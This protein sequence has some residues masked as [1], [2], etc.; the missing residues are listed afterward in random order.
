[1]AWK[2]T[3][4]VMA[5]QTAPSDELLAHLTERA[6]AVVHVVVPTTPYRSDAPSGREHAERNLEE[7]LGRLRAAGIEAS[8]EIGD[9]DP[10]TAVNEAWDPVRFDAVVVSTLPT[11]ASRWLRIDVPRR[12]ERM[13]GV[14]VEHV[15]ATPRREYRAEPPKPPRDRHG[16]LTPLAALE[17]SP[18]RPGRLPSS[19]RDA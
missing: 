3:V 13:T 15:V 1:M 11:G 17:R 14:P 7:A 10:I 18:D 16:I 2:R 19:P 4:L 9:S 5:N 12:L 6:E 8:G